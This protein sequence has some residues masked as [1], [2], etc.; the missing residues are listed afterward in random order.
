M[1][2]KTVENTITIQ[3]SKEKV[4]DALTQPE[5]TKKYMFGCE[6]VSDWKAG[7][8]LL[9]RGSYEGKAVD[10]VSGYIISILPG[11]L[12][13]YSVI[14][15][16]ASYPLTP[17]NHLTVRYELLATNEN[18]TVLNVAQYGFE[19]AAEGEQ[20]YLD[21]YNNGDGWNPILKAI[22]ELLEA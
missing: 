6:T 21:V 12:L 14:D 13:E 20:R 5:Q 4:W 11:S 22:K 17:E 1:Q 10:F 7:S 9:W 3:A 8:P 16:N 15:P 19:N 2:N 18:T